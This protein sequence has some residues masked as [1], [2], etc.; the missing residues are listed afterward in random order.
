MKNIEK[1]PTG[2]ISVDRDPNMTQISNTK[3]LERNPAKRN[4][5]LRP[6]WSRYSKY[7]IGSQNFTKRKSKYAPKTKSDRAQVGCAAAREWATEEA[8]RRSFRRR[9]AARGG[10][11][12]R[13]PGGV[14]LV[15]SV[16]FRSGWCR[17]VWTP[18]RP[19]TVVVKFAVKS[20]APPQL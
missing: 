11:S 7:A 17:V 5:P 9:V 13:R 1:Y 20:P 12:R 2:E 18:G 6:E 8:T 19:P 15:S 16:P 3:F 10:A 4:A 14:G